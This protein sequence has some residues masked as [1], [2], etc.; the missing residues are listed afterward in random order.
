MLGFNVRSFVPYKYNIVC[1][2]SFFF[3]N[4][5]NVFSLSFHH[6]LI[7]FLLPLQYF[8]STNVCFTMCFYN[9]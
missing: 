7:V 1:L 4:K 6:L 9:I 2:L 8:I 3:H 5:N